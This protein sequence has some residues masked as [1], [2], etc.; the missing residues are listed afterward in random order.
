MKT[1][2]AWIALAIFAAVILVAGWF[3]GVIAQAVQ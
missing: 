2:L 3:G 1:K